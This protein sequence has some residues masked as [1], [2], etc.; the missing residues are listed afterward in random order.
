M[1][2]I[3]KFLLK[4]MFYISYI[5]FIAFGITLLIMLLNKNQEFNSLNTQISELTEKTS[6]Q[7]NEIKELKSQNTELTT[8]NEAMKLESLK[9]DGLGKISGKISGQLLISDSQIT[10]YQFV[11]AQN[12]KNANLQYC[13]N[14]SSITQSYSL[15]LP[16]G[17]YR[18]YAKAI[19]NL[20]EITLSDYEGLYTEYVKCL[21]E[22]AQNECD[23]TKLDKEQ[24][25]EVKPGKQI[26]E[27][28]PVDWR[29]VTQ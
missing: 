25:V 21:N 5:F 22:K 14:V 8:E 16:E 12:K 17:S 19:S 2:K 20:N 7:E 28:N 26:D 18:V 1:K 10:Q 6:S 11:C 13:L 23:Q 3:L 27:V 4:V 24:T 9:Q 29:K 15:L